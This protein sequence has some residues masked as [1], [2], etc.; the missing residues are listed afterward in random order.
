MNIPIIQSATPK[1]GHILIVTFTNGKRKKYDVNPLTTRES[2][3]PLRIE[4]FFKNVTVE[5]GG[6]AV[7]WNA[8]IDISEC[9]LWQ[10][11]EE[12]P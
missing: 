9:E 11:G 2:F 4:A 1:D 7:S 6:Y 8:E 10:N 5:P 3:A 12:M